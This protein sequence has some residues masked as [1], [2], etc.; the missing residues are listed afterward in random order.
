MIA[1]EKS[2]KI[3][4][5]FVSYLICFSLHG[6]LQSASR[7]ALWHSDVLRVYRVTPSLVSAVLPQR[8]RIALIEPHHVLARM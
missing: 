7:H 3:N 4:D 5:Q 1:P 2:K 8:H 6:W